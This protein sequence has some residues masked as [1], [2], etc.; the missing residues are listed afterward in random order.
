MESV[1]LDGDAYVK[2]IAY[3]AKGGGFPRQRHVVLLFARADGVSFEVPVTQL[4]FTEE[5]TSGA[6]GGGAVSIDGIIST[7]RGNAGSW[8]A[9]L[10]KRPVGEWE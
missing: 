8:L 1:S 3:N 5:N 7:R 10:G 2:R 6:V 4:R 9:M